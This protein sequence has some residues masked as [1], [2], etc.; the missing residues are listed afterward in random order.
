MWRWS[1]KTAAGITLAGL[2]VAVGLAFADDKAEAPDSRGGY[3]HTERIY[4]EYGQQPRR[5]QVGDPIAGSDWRND[6]G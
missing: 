5:Y 6:G 2:S 1:G 3:I 4:Q